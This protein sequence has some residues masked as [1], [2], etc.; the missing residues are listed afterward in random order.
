M[1][2]VQGGQTVLIVSDSKL[3]LGV[4]TEI[5]NWSGQ[6]FIV[7]AASTGNSALKLAE[8]HD[9]AIHLLISD[10]HMPNI[11]GPE[12][13][14]AL[15][16]QRPNMEILL[17]SGVGGVLLDPGWRILRKPF[18]PNQIMAEIGDLLCSEQ[19]T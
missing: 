12:L 10:L 5:L 6:G 17:I 4:V 13:A 19:A 15:Q 3:L 18:G 11:S 7:L 8:K 14:R 2:D 9:G 1:S 16:A